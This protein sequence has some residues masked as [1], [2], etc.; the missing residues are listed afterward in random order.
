MKRD[1]LDI[2][3]SH[4]VKLLC[5]GICSRCHKYLGVK[6]RGLHCAHCFT[7]AKRCVR[8]D[9]DN[10]TALCYGCHRYLDG[11]PSEKTEFFMEL[12]GTK[13]F[14]VLDRR[15]HTPKKIDE[16]AIEKDLKERILLLEKD[17]ENNGG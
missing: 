13:R 8:F 9:R 6:S 3:F 11:R 15:A 10:A 7:R 16:E 12:L 14:N 5:A 17:D 2:L 4:Y 1:K